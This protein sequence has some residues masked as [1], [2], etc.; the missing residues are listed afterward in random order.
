MAQ[1]TS[2]AQLYSTSQQHTVPEIRRRALGLRE[3]CGRLDVLIIDHIGLV[4]MTGRTRENEV[5]AAMRDVKALAIELDIVIIVV[6]QYNRAGSAAVTVR[7]PELGDL[8][9]SSEIEQSSCR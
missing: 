5:S 8:K 9:D 1:R 4:K 3:R 7:P 2:A 6:A